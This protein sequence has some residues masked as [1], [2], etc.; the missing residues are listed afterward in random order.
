MSNSKVH[1]AVCTN[2]KSGSASVVS[3]RRQAGDVARAT[4]TESRFP[5]TS[6]RAGSPGSAPVRNDNTLG[7]AGGEWLS[8]G[9]AGGLR[10]E[11]FF[12][13]K[14]MTPLPQNDNVGVRIRRMVLKGS[15]HPRP[16][17]FAQGRLC[18]SK[19]RRDEDG[20]PCSYCP[21]TLVTF[22]GAVGLSLHSKIG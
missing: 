21:V 5:S 19:R 13:Y 15:Q 11:S 8:A 17:D 12:F 18:L 16:F 20:A 14:R 6:L 4:R 2:R 22:S 7:R 3:V 1:R 10:W 9:G